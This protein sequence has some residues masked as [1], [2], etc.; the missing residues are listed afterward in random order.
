M[1]NI[2]CIFAQRTYKNRY[3]F[4]F[5]FARHKLKKATADFI[6]A[7]SGN[8]F[9]PHVTHYLFGSDIIYG[10]IQTGQF[11]F[12]I[13]NTHLP[14]GDKSAPSENQRQRKLFCHWTPSLPFSLGSFNS[15]Q[16]SSLSN[17]FHIPLLVQLTDFECCD[18]RGK[19]HTG[20]LWVK[21]NLS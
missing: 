13:K 21:R 7:S 19:R 4:D 15:E 18:K 11:S 3:L 5:Y 16:Q 6:C 9:I 12:I 14:M 1:S 17:A 2:N 20:L 8:G 10:K